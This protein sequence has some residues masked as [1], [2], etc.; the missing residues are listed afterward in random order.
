MFDPFAIFR[1]LAT[2]GAAVIV[3]TSTLLWYSRD[4]LVPAGGA[5]WR[6]RAVLAVLV[7]SLIGVAA[8]WIGVA[9]SAAAAAGISVF[10]IDASVIVT[11][12][13]KTGVGQITMVEIA[14]AMAACIPAALALAWVKTPSLSNN[15]LLCAAFI[16]GLGLIIYPFNSHPVTL[17]QLVI[18]LLSS[19]AHRLALAVWLGG[20]PALILLI[21]VGPLP[22]DSRQLAAVVLRR[23]SRLATIAMVVIL[24]S[25]VLLTWFLVRN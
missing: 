25:G 3:G 1:A 16:A 2:L 5:T 20:L 9:G 13:T 18:G 22:E 19:I 14:C 17:E 10:S 11:F 6:H 15:A 12:L 4:A 8:T 21:G 7:A 23:F 24:A